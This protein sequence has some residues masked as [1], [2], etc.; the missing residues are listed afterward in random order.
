MYR[1]QELVLAKMECLSGG[2]YPAMLAGA[3]YVLRAI[4]QRNFPRPSISVGPSYQENDLPI[5]LKWVVEDRD[6]AVEFGPKGV[7]GYS[8]GRADDLDGDDSPRPAT[9][10]LR[11]ADGM[12]SAVWWL[13]MGYVPAPP[14]P[15]PRPTS[16]TLTA[17]MF[18]PPSMVKVGTALPMND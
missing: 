2:R 10:E 17:Q 11:D 9:P 16:N 14:Q 6:L 7:V 4:D 12:K 3:A 18:R 8:L 15:P 1:W 5:H 13:L